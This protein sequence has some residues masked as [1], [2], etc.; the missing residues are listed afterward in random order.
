MW[1]EILKAA[2]RAAR[3]Q[4]SLPDPTP[5]LLRKLWPSLVGPA[6][7]HLTSPLKIEEKTLFIAVR[8]QGLHDE[9]RYRPGPLLARLK[10]FA[11]WEI[12]KLSLSIDDQAGVPVHIPSS[13]SPELPSS[14]NDPSAEAEGS[15][16]I[17]APEGVDDELRG[18]LNSIAAHRR[19]KNS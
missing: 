9:W 8:H 19:R 15:A 11:P 14:P 4:N 3:D 1:N 2:A 10:Q 6:L 18:I 7:A 17:D 16:D 12:E 13:F 5:E